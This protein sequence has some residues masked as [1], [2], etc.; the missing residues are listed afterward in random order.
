MPTEIFYCQEKYFNEL[1]REIQKRNFRAGM[2]SFGFRTLHFT[3]KSWTLKI[4]RI[5][6]K[7]GTE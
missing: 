6:V 3:F 4:K 5:N 2:L 1:P 7:K